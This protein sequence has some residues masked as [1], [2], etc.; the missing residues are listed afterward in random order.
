MT[1]RKKSQV[2][3]KS[4][5]NAARFKKQPP[6]RSVTVSSSRQPVDLVK[7]A[8]SNQKAVQKLETVAERTKKV[9]NKRKAEEGVEEGEERMISSFA[10]RHWVVLTKLNQQ[11]PKL[12]KCL[13]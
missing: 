6:P 1:V 5:Q 10:I 4:S 9:G 11:I 12:Q 13:C 8:N 3:S 2:N 7:A